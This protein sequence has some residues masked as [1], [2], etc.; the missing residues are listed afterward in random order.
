M[1]VVVR[2][3]FKKPRW[4][5]LRT[6][7]R[8]AHERHDCWTCPNPIEPGDQYTGEVW[9]WESRDY[10]KRNKFEVR[11]YHLE[12]PEDPEEVRRREELEEEFISECE[13]HDCER[14]EEE[15]TEEQPQVA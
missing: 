5:H 2:G 8:I 15:E 6:Y 14:A 7:K 9:V 11:K 3:K 1:P 10:G 13:E 4:R 12:C